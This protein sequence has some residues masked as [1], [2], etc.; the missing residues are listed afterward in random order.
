M[1]RLSKEGGKVRR[2]AWKLLIANFVDYNLPSD[3]EEKG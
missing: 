2:P 3:H 1:G